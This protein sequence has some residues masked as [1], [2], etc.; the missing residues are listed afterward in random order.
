MNTYRLKVLAS[1]RE[2]LENPVLLLL[3][4]AME[5]LGVRISSFSTKRLWREPW[6]IWHLHWPEHIL[7]GRSASGCAIELLKLWVKLKIAQFRKTRIFWTAHNLR[8]H[9]RKYVLLER[10]F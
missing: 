6:D 3:Y 7:N 8:P 2:D 10:I 1:P 9:E 5:K 4:N